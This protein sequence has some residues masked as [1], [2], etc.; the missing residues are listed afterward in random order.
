VTY[1]RKEVIGSCTLY[2]GDN[3][4]L[5]GEIECDA[6]V[7][8]PPYI[9][10]DAPCSTKNNAKMGL[11]KF[12]TESYSKITNGFNVKGIFA[13]LKSVCKPFNMFMFCSNSQIAGLMTHCQNNF[14]STTLLI[15]HKT[16]A[17]PFANGTWRSDIEFIVH[18]RD[19]GSVFQGGAV[20][21]KKVSEYPTV[22]DK[23]H[24][25]VKPLELIKK[26]I[27]ICSNKG[28]TILDPFMGSGTTLVACAKMNRK[29]I[30]IELD[31][32]YFDIAC[33]RVEEAYRQPDLFYG[34]SK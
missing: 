19:K 25:T 21:K 4:D 7:T 5:I 8:D 9:L 3:K 10:N 6:I 13:S 34:T 1:K 17:A 32:G 26:Y 22:I 16:N 20:I 18:S 14:D 15:W 33:K 29:G 12:H 31:E 28:Q 30:G 2:L 23:A 27:G 11:Q 24:P